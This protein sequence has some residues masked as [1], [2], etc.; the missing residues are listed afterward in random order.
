VKEGSLEK[1][2]EYA[3]PEELLVRLNATP[4][5]K[6]AFEALTPG[7]RKSYIFHILSAKRAETRAA[8]ADTAHP[9]CRSLENEIDGGQGRNRTTDTRIFNPLLYQLSYLAIDGKGAY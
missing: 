3:V 2:S 8:R 5:L 9:D 4:V 1:V 6:A 7:R